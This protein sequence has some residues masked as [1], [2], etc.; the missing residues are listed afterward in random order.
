MITEKQKQ[1]FEKLKSKYGK[2]VLPSFEAIAQEFGF[3]HKNSVWQYFNKFKDY[4]LIEEINGRFSIS[5]ALFGAIEF[6]SSVKAG[7]ADV[8][9]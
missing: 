7:F 9:A 3:K 1:F 5:K 4:G 6:S 2:E 8:G